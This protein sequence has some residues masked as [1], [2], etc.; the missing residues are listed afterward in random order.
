[1][2][3]VRVAWCIVRDAY[4]CC[5][6]RGACACCVCILRGAC[7]RCVCLLRVVCCMLRVRGACCPVQLVSAETEAPN[8][9]ILATDAEQDA[10]KDKAKY[11]GPSSRVP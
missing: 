10:A 11:W 1:M 3:H 4:A 2:L 7:A 8:K 6:L 9:L 5:V